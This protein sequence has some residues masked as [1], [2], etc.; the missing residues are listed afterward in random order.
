MLVNANGYT[1]GARSE[2]FALRPAPVQVS[3]MGFAGT[4][5]ARS[6]DYALTDRIVTPPS[7]R[8]YTY[9]EALLLHPHSY[10]VCD[11]AQ[12]AATSAV[13]CASTRRTAALHRGVRAPWR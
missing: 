6:I 10:F 7:T 9:A 4:L 3:F 12:S 13:T 1:K 5:A 2:L 11:H 8:A